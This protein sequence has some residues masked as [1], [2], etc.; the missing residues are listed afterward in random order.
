MGQGI[1]PRGIGL[2]VVQILFLSLVWVF[3][4]LRLLAKFTIIKKFSLGDFFMY[5]AALTYTAHATITIRGINS[6]SWEG[7]SNAIQAESIALHSWFLCEVIY[8]T[9]SAL[10]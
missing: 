5:T 9:L 4:I 6:S 3:I 7:Q 2:F 1:D 10:Q 8:P